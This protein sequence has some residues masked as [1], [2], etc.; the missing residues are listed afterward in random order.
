LAVDTSDIGAV[1]SQE[2]NN[3]VDHPVCFFSKTFI[4][5]QNNYSTIEKDCLAFKLAIQHFESYVSLKKTHLS[6][7][8]FKKKNNKTKS[9]IVK[10]EMLNTK[11]LTKDTL[12]YL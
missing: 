7:C 3:G 4:K 12:I 1:L 9:E 10:V 6:F 11:L 2:D 8:T 5:H